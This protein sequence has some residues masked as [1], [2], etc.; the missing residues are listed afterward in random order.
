MGLAR[1]LKQIIACLR[2]HMAAVNA[3][4]H[5]PPHDELS[6]VDRTTTQTQTNITSDGTVF[7]RSVHSVKQATVSAYSTC[8]YV[9]IKRDL[10]KSTATDSLDLSV[11]LKCV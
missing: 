6:T 2:L 1:L 3:T 8:V 4:M 9:Y 10:H 11:L 5:A 7:I